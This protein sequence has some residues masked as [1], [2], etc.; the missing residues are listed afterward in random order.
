ME[1]S[2]M[3]GR[4]QISDATRSLLGDLVDVEAREIDI[5]GFGRQTTYLMR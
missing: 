5:K 1:S 4:I 3:P 2:G